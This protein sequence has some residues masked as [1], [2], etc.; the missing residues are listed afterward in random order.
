[1]AQ[2]NQLSTTQVETVVACV[3]DA[4]MLPLAGNT[5]YMLMTGPDVQSTG[6]CVHVFVCAIL[7]MM[8]T[9]SSTPRSRW[10]AKTM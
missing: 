6:A 4:A 3:L 10:C 9:A 8:S 2:G 1:M 7:V 5:V